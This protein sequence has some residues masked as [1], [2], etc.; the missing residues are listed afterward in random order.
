MMIVYAAIEKPNNDGMIEYIAPLIQELQNMSIS[1]D[2]QVKTDAIKMKNMASQILI[3]VIK[4]IN[5]LTTLTS[6]TLLL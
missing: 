2:I 1:F 6:F 4:S 3:L 5:I